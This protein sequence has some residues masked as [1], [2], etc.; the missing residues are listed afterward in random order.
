MSNME[1]R[2]LLNLS[3]QNVLDCI[4]ENF[5]LKNFPRG[6]FAR[7]SLEKC[8]VRSTDGYYCA[9]ISTVYYISRPSLSQNP[10]SASACQIKYMFICSCERYIKHCG[11]EIKWRM[12]LAVVNAICVRGLKKFRT[13]MGFEPAILQCSLVNIVEVL[14]FF[15]K[16]LTQLYKLRSQLRGSFFIWFHYCCFYTWFI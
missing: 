12:I 15:S 5:N 10:P 9:H 4:S 1:S 8:S 3:V 16:I 11:N 13:S 7:N 14:I 2:H 6:A